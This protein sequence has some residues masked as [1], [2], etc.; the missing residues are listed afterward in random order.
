MIPYYYGPYAEMN[1]IFR[2]RPGKPVAHQQTCPVCG[3]TLVNIYRRG[4]VWKCKKCWGKEG[5]ASE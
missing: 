3:R 1:R 4:K 5:G 2:I